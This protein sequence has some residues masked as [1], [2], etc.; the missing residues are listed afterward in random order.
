MPRELLL[1][2]PRAVRLVAYDEA[3]LEPRQVRARGVVSGVSH[4][5]ELALY[6][7]VSAFDRK[8][9][10][11]ALRLFV[12]EPEQDA[13]PMRLGY[14]W[15]GV[16]QDAGDGVHGVQVGDRLHLSLPHRE[17]QTAEIADDARAPWT[18]LPSGLSP[19][20]ATLLQSTTIAL[21]AVHDARLKAGDR[22]V[23]FED[24]IEVGRH[25]ASRH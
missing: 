24:A 10:D 20:R 11:L 16:V 12:D 13:Y 17:T 23:V 2:G 25:D 9:F 8:R 7:G 1:T 21:Q 18:V 14:E 6:R 4:G 19:E 22:T 3:P 5:T 15:I